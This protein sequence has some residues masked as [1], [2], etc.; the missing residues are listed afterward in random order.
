MASM[1]DNGE[2]NPK[3]SLN[4]FP[5]PPIDSL[6]WAAT[7]WR[8]TNDSD[9]HGVSGGLFGGRPQS[10]VLLME[11]HMAFCRCLPSFSV[12]AKTAC[13]AQWAT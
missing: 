8:F 7:V 13:E 5:A 10:A 4:A 12:R 3:M 1:P 11:P 9:R 6:S 2:L